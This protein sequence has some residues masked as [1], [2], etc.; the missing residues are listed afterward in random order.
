[1]RSSTWTAGNTASVGFDA[2]DVLLQIS[3]DMM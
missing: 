3:L 2:M 1:M